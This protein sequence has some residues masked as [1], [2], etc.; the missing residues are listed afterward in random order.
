MY[1]WNWSGATG[2][3]TCPGH[4]LMDIRDPLLFVIIRP[5]EVEP[6]GPAYR[7]RSSA[8][9]GDDN[10]RAAF[11]EIEAAGGIN[12]A[13]IQQPRSLLDFAPLLRAGMRLDFID[14]QDARRELSERGFGDQ[15]QRLRE[16]ADVT[17][18][19]RLIRNEQ[20]LIAAVRQATGSQ[21]FVQNENLSM[22]RYFRVTEFDQNEDP[23]WWCKAYWWEWKRLTHQWNVSGGPCVR[24]CSAYRMQFLI[25]RPPQGAVS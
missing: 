9:V 7:P 3:W 18:N 1:W 16:L 20:E 17:I 22:G 2:K 12:P 5:P 24:N 23:L 4:P 25:I 11:D 10:I 15:C 13:D 21:I 14:Y 6:A 8:Q 19:E